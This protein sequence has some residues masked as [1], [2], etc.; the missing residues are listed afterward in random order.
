MATTAKLKVFRD[1]LM[2]SLE[3]EREAAVQLRDA[4]GQAEEPTTPLQDGHQVEHVGEEDEEGGLLLVKSNR[5]GRRD[6][7]DSLAKLRAI[8]FLVSFSKSIS[9]PFFVLYLQKEVGL[10]AGEVGL[11]AALQIVGGYLVSPAISVLVDRYQIHK[12]TWVAS[13]LVGIVPVQL[14]VLAHNFGS[15]LAVALSMAAL[16]APVRSLLDGQTLRFLGDQQHEYGKI[17]L[18]GAVGWGAGSLVGG[19]IVQFLGN[20][21]A[22]GLAGASMAAVAGIVLSLDFSRLPSWD[23]GR[24][25]GLAFRESAR[26]LIPSA[27][28]LVFLLVAIVAGFGATGLQSLLLMFL[29]DLGAPDFLEGLALSLATVSEVPMFYASGTIIKRH[30]APTLMLAS[31]A[32]FVIRSTLVSFLV[33]PWLVLPLQLLHGLTFAGAWAAGVEIARQNSPPGLETSAQSRF[34]LAY[35]GVGGLSGSIVGGLLY[36]SLGARTMYRIKAALFA[37]VASAWLAHR[38]TEAEKSEEEARAAALKAAEM[39]PTTAVP[40][41]N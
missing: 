29:S 41:V 11:V 34:S 25:T 30:G 24:G 5:F 7:V 1:N 26:R 36:D 35:N 14:I 8:Y 18:W 17:R 6:R 31:M 38:Q 27:K 3:E 22:F 21:A 19:T 15:A 4:V 13:I 39:T 33:N 32:A 37:V 40:R 16:D 2:L 20:Q 28:Y 10:S 23:D 9:T 12:Q